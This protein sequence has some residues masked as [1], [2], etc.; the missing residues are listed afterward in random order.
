MINIIKFILS[1]WKSI[2]SLIRSEYEKSEIAKEKIGEQQK[3]IY[4]DVQ[5]LLEYEC[6][7]FS[8]EQKI[9]KCYQYINP[10]SPDKVDEIKRKVRKYFGEKQYI[11]LC[12]I[13]ELCGQA[14]MIDY[15]IGI[16]FESIRYS[17]VYPELR[18]VLIE[19][20]TNMSIPESIQHFLGT[21]SFTQYASNGCIKT[22]DYIEESKKLNAMDKQIYVKRK[23][24]EDSLKNTMEEFI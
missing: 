15:D 18:K 13:L 19:S 12:E 4:K 11:K 17:E 8:S 23:N 3:L 9:M 10:L 16:I 2:F 14:K 7:Y 21:I 20:H 6:N 24:F 1:N 22:Y 5:N